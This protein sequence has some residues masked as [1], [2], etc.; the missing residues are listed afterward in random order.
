MN[1]QPL[2]FEVG[3]TLVLAQGSV[4]GSPGDLYSGTATTPSAAQLPFANY[5]FA[6]IQEV[7]VSQMSIT[8]S[9]NNVHQF[10][11]E[12]DG[13]WTTK[14]R[15]C[16]SQGTSSQRP[17][18]AAQRP[19][20]RFPG[21]HG[22]ADPLVGFPPRP[23]PVVPCPAYIQCLLYF[24]LSREKVPHGQRRARCLDLSLVDS[25]EPGGVRDVQW[26]HAD[27][28]EGSRILDA[29]HNHPH[30]RGGLECGREP[31]ACVLDRLR[32]AVPKKSELVGETGPRARRSLC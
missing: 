8:D 31:A 18:G 7:N 2:E 29:Q 30:I 27:T 26:D 11:R 20:V 16:T 10:P 5:Q 6:F 12:R 13:S 3:T 22:H 28:G 1:Y 14:T 24:V 19:W 23:P 25:V 21:P 4:V 9:L 32:L 17:P 15:R